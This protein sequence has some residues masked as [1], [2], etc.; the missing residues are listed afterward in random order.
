MSNKSS[1]LVTVSDLALY[2]DH[3]YHIIA[4]MISE[5]KGVTSEVTKENFPVL[6]ANMSSH[7]FFISAFSDCT[8]W[9]MYNSRTDL[10]VW[11]WDAEYKNFDEDEE[12]E[13]EEEE[14]ESYYPDLYALSAPWFKALKEMF[15]DGD[16]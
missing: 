8:V 4:T 11:Y 5:G 16:K 2:L 9:R 12:E 15:E 7:Q 10:D 3:G 1:Y 13:E 6:V 14:K